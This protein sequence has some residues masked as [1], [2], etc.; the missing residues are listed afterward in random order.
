MKLTEP[1]HPVTCQLKRCFGKQQT[2]SP[3]TQLATSP[4]YPGSY[5]LR[6]PHAHG[7]HALCKTMH[8]GS[9]LAANNAA[10]PS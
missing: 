8:A 10:A 6:E 7:R 9:V 3:V 5:A 2:M 1:N 4:E